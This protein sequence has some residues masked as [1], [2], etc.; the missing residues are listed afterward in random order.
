MDSRSCARERRRVGYSLRW[1]GRPD[2]IKVSLSLSLSLLGGGCVGGASHRAHDEKGCQ[3]IVIVGRRFRV[4][5]SIPDGMEAYSLDYASLSPQSLGFPKNRGR[6][7]RVG[8]GGQPIILPGPLPPQ[9]CEKMEKTAFGGGQAPAPAR[10]LVYS[11]AY[12]LSAN[13]Y[14]LGVLSDIMAMVIR[15]NT[16]KNGSADNSC[17]DS[18]IGYC[19]ACGGDY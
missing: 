1:W 4:P 3:Y 8:K 16:N 6:R 19:P 15:E 5:K 10:N 13:H 14:R 18:C 2:P 12:F 7:P 17:E 9:F 11:L